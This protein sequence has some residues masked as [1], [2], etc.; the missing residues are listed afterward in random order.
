MSDQQPVF[1][2]YFHIWVA[3]P[4]CQTVTKICLSSPAQQFLPC[5]CWVGSSSQGWFLAPSAQGSTVGFS[6]FISSPC[7]SF[8]NT[9]PSC[10]LGR[11]S[12]AFSGAAFAF[13]KNHLSILLLPLQNSLW[14]WEMW[15]LFWTGQKWLLKFILVLAHKQGA[16]FA[17]LLKSSS[18]SVVFSGKK[19][20]IGIFWWHDYIFY[21]LIELLIKE[22]WGCFN[23]LLTPSTNKDANCQE[24]VVIIVLCG[25]S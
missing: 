12:K 13:Y 18:V 14:S 9:A 16:P 11:Y 1:W 21:F 25:S 7:C 15:I 8:G 6:Q 4:C 22:K 17:H 23:S 20:E 24:N 19:W 3:L 10:R 5:R 2:E